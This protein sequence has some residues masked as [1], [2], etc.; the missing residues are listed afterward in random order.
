[1]G[2]G[3]YRQAGGGGGFIPDQEPCFGGESETVHDQ[4]SDKIVMRLS[5]VSHI[6]GVGLV[7]FR[8][9]LYIIKFR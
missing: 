4:D 2:W 9:R 6:Q 8:Y 1:M 5:E 3:Y 7:S